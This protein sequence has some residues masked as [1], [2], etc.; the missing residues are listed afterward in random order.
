MSGPAYRKLEIRWV[1]LDPT[2]GAETKK[3]R[4][5]VILQ[6]DLVNQGSRT[7]IVAPVLHGHKDWPF[8]VNL[9]S[10]KMNGLDTDRHINLKQLRAVDVSRVRNKQGVLEKRHVEPLKAALSIVFNL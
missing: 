3:R 6:D 1:E 2:R 7:V 4:P 8:A 10:S 5:C 9:K